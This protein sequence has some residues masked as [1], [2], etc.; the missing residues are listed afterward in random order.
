VIAIKR[1]ILSI[2]L[3]QSDVLLAEGLILPVTVWVAVRSEI[4]RSL[5]CSSA[6][7][8]T[9]TPRSDWEDVSFRVINTDAYHAF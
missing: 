5:T 2:G 8:G 4:H 6:T 1:Q 9:R 7:L 3:R